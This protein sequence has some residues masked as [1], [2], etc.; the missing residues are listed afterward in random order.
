MND[1][2][3]TIDITDDTNDTDTSHKL[4]RTLIVHPSFCCKTYLLLNKFQ[5]NCF[6][7]HEQKLHIITRSPEQYTNI[8]I[9]V[10]EEE[11]LEDKTKYGFQSYCVVFDDMLDSN[12]KLIDPFFTRRSH[13]NLKVY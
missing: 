4:N 2:I 11:D 5:I 6:D 9:D 7:N 12:Q 3:D 13:N 8:E 10:S 1:P